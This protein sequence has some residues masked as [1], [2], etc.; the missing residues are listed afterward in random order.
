MNTRKWLSDLTPLKEIGDMENKSVERVLSNDV[1][2]GET[3]GAIG[4]GT[5]DKG[6]QVVMG[7]TNEGLS[8]AKAP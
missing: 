5:I 6:K 2:A 3:Q 7:D 8:V 4:L 1:L